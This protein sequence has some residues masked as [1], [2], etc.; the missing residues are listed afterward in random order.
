MTLRFEHSLR[1]LHWRNNQQ[2]WAFAH[3][4]QHVALVEASP[5]GLTSLTDLPPHGEHDV[6]MTQDADHLAS[7]SMDG[8]NHDC[9]HENRQPD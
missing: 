9:R 8:K 3:D 7:A 5:T 1:R 4:G 6:A 2:L